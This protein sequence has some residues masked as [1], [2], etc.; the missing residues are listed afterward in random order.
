MNP[1]EFLCRHN[2]IPYQIRIKYKNRFENLTFDTDESG[3]HTDIPRLKKG[4]VGSQVL[5]ECSL[6]TALMWLGYLAM[7]YLERNFLVYSISYHFHVFVADVEMTERNSIEIS[8]EQKQTNRCEV[9]IQRMGVSLN[10]ESVTIEFVFK[11][12]RVA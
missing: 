12:V 10:C 8:I 9:F 2:D 7:L 6:K 4:K 1:G 5:L 11:M 3:W